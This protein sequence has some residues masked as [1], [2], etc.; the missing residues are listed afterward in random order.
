MI[1]RCTL[2]LLVLIAM[3]T[4]AWAKDVTPEAAKT[5]AQE[6]MKSRFASTEWNVADVTPVMYEGQKAYYIVSFSPEGWTLIS[7][8]DNTEPLIGFSD[9]GRS[10]AEGMPSAI[11][12]VVNCFSRRIVERSRFNFDVAFRL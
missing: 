10:V 6:I 4:S 12:N 2:S 9:T 11:E 3:I 5:K 1:K 7:A 8:D